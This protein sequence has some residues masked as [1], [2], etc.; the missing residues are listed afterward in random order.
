MIS[1]GSFNVT[2]LNEIMILGNC[3]SRE[4][5]EIQFAFIKRRKTGRGTWLNRN[6]TA[7]VYYSEKKREQWLIDSFV[8]RQ[9]A[10]NEAIDHW[11]PTACPVSREK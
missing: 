7:P 8:E 2:T 4:G 11:E 9:D 6:W 1:R 5:F 3:L 10:G